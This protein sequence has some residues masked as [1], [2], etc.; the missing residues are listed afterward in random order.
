MGYTFL[1]LG[2]DLFALWKWSE[3]MKNLINSFNNQ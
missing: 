1:I 2:S 3:K